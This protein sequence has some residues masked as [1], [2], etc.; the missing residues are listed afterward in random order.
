MIRGT[1]ILASHNVTFTSILDQKFVSNAD[2]VIAYLA[3]IATSFIISSTEK[4]IRNKLMSTWLQKHSF[5]FVIT[6]DRQCNLE[7]KRQKLVLLKRQ[8]MP[9][10]VWLY[11]K[12]KINI[13][14]TPQDVTAIENGGKF[15]DKKDL[16]E[17][18][19]TSLLI[20]F[21]KKLNERKENCWNRS[22][23][24]EISIDHIKILF[25]HPHHWTSY[26]CPILYRG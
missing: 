12:P 26:N 17:S 8:A 15:C 18:T 3:C 5:T 1:I 16:S 9:S 11:R 20:P 22:G 4:Y 13:K 10:Y 14:M 6:D 2:P 21:I 24:D 19:K 23:K 7:K 25:P